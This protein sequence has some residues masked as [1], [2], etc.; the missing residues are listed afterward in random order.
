MTSSIEPL[1]HVLFVDDSVLFCQATE[2]EALL[3]NDLLHKYADGSGQCVN[4]EKSSAFFSS[5]CPQTMRVRLS[6]ILG[7][8]YQDNFG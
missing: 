2:M 1:S 8:K 4:L 7:I 3:G 6:A 5:S